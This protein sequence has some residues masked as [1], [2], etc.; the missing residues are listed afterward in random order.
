MDK[1]ECFGILEQVF[2]LKESG[3]RETP[4]ECFECP[5]R[6][7]CLRNAIST[8]EGIGMMAEKIDQTPAKGFRE[9]LKRWSERKEL[10][11]QMEKKREK[12][13]KWWK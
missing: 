10:S 6:V 9:R 1:K 12:G 4:S 5:D 13:R 11:R 7:L 3:L 2:P 8:E